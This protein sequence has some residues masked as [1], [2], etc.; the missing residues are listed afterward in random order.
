M[1]MRH[2]V[3]FSIALF[4]ASASVAKPVSAAPDSF[5]KQV[6][7]LPWEGAGKHGVTERGTITLGAGTRFMGPKGTDEFLKLTG[8]LPEETTSMI[9][10]ANLGWAAFYS[11][12]DIGYVKDDEK[13]DADALLSDIK[14]GQEAGNEERKAQGL[15]PLT[16]VG[17]AVPPHYD[18]ATHNLEY[19]I[20]LGD[21]SGSNVNYHMRML[22]RRG[23]MDATLLTSAQTLQSDLIAFR[24]ANKGFAFEADESYAAFKDGDK[25][26]EYGLAALVSGGAAAA[27]M[28]TGLFAGLLKMLA[29]S[30]KLI[31]L[32]VVA[33]WAALRG[34]FKGLLGKPNEEE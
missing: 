18:P 25:I 8:N 10:P 21:G 26:S 31:M 34:F 13:I 22:G 15:G 5:E 12:N 19:G 29:A 16:V 17:W 11:F 27:A 20:T 23:V 4:V 24:E 6:A 2:W 9:A 14:D 28:K 3:G 7:A 1:E 32:A 30:W 33:G